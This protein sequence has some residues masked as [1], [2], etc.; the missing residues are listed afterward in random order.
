MRDK[1][2]DPSCSAKD[3]TTR[4]SRVERER[5]WLEENEQAIAEAN[6]YVEKHGLPLAKYRQF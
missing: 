3:E 1:K 6:A 2:P 4:D 5:L